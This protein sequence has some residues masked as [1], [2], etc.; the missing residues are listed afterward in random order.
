MVSYISP[1]T[2]GYIN[3]FCKV[4]QWCIIMN[5]IA[6]KLHWLGRAKPRTKRVY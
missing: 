5:S 2:D 3:E 6:Y 4:M 1:K